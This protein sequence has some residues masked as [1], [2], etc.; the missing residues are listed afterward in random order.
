[1]WLMVSW[2][3]LWYT[4]SVLQILAYVDV[5]SAWT[6]DYRRGVVEF[7]KSVLGV[8]EVELFV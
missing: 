2:C 5:S 3:E 7:C 1:V 8:L 4:Q 6:L